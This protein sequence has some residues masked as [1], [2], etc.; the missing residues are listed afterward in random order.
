MDPPEKR[1]IREG[2]GY[3]EALGDLC[4]ASSPPS[5]SSPLIAPSGLEQAF[6]KL[7]SAGIRPFPP[8]HLPSLSFVSIRSEERVPNA[9]FSSRSRCFRR[10]G[11]SEPRPECPRD[12]RGGPLT[13]HSAVALLTVHRNGRIEGGG[14]FDSIFSST[15]S[16]APLPLCRFSFSLHLLAHSPRDAM[17]LKTSLALLLA[18]GTVNADPQPILFDTLATVQQARTSRPFPSSRRGYPADLRL[19]SK[20]SRLQCPESSSGDA[21]VFSHQYRQGRNEDVDAFVPTSYPTVTQR[22]GLTLVLSAIATST[23]VVFSTATETVTTSA[24]RPPSSSSA[25][26]DCFLLPRSPDRDCCSHD[27]DYYGLVRPFILPSQFPSNASLSLRPAATVQATITGAPGT[28]T[29]VLRP[30]FPSSL[31]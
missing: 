30:R 21:V 11:A 9:N 8:L 4:V 23:S 19:A 29:Y 14:A 13:P 17:L 5:S 27:V 22:R 18:A 6:H 1:S 26:P 7:S 10:W 25:V 28:S 15:R 16:A 31:R 20:S 2:H 12:G 24:F 3:S